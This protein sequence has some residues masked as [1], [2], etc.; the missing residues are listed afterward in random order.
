MTEEQKNDYRKILEKEFSDKDNEIDT[1]LMYV[2]MG[3]LGFFMAF[4]EKYLTKDPVGVQDADFKYFL[5]L[6][7]LFLLGTFILM[8]YR[9]SITI[10]S[11]YSLM[12]FLDNMAPNSSEGDKKLDELWK[13]NDERMKKIRKFIYF[14]LGFGI[15]FQVLF[16]VF[17]FFSFC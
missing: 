10:Q 3:A 11:A 12:K 15:G 14:S 13:K 9:K 17:N 5:V 2:T 6:S 1:H 16:F 4:N 8:L 7:L